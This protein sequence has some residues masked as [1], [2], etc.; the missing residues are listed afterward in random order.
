MTAMVLAEQRPSMALAG[1]IEAFFRY[2]DRTIQMLRSTAMGENENMSCFFD[3]ALIGS[4]ARTKELKELDGI[5][6]RP[7][8]APR[9]S[10]GA[11][12]QLPL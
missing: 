8:R 12:R 6:V 1:F 7:I 4:L 10:A 11:L 2:M 9:G 5:S 3:R